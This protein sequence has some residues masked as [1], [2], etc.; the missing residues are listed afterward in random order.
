MENAPNI[1][2]FWYFI[3]V[4]FVFVIALMI[5]ANILIK[6]RREQNA[7][8][9]QLLGKICLGLDLVCAIPIILVVGYILYLRIG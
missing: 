8:K 1:I 4:I 7:D 6:K 9:L 3:I 2:L 5:A